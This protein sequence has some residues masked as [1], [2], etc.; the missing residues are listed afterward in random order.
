MA[1]APAREAQDQAERVRALD[2]TGS[3][4]VQAPAGSG[5]TELLIQRFLKLLGRVDQPESIVAITFTRKAAAEMRYRAIGALQNASGPEPE[6]PHER[7]TWE[8]AQAAL[9]RNEEC[10]WRLL[11]HPSR[12]R[13]Q[14]IDSLSA[15]LVRQMPWV[16][17]MGAAP[18][19]E[20]N[21]EHLY[22]QAAR[23]TLEMLDSEN[24]LAG[25]SGALARLLSHLDN[26][27]AAVEGLLSLMLG[28]RD[29]WLRHVVGNPASVGFRQDLEFALRQIVED[30]LEQLANQFPEDRVMETVALARFAAG[31]LA[32]QGSESPLTAC[33]LMLMLL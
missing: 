8:L 4:I 22:R 27:V 33:A 3:F 21:V 17:R 19:P 24:T 16:S 11:E 32:R 31:T 6:S 26:N 23:A 25:V 5:K 7:Y 12:L 29:Q 9:V 10:D 18:R 28:S 1:E 2:H 30:T 13:I 15:S 20:E 14:T